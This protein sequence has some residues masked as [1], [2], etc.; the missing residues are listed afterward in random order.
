MAEWEI[1]KPLG[2]CSGTGR[3]IEVGE[4]YYAALIQTHEGLQRADFSKEYWQQNQPQVYCHWKSK[5]PNPEEKK[6]IFID[7]DM[8][9]TFFDRLQQESE[10]EKI[11]FRFVLA[12]VLMRKRR[13]KYQGTKNENGLEIWQLKVTGEDR[14][15]DV[16]NPQLDESQIEQLTGQIGQILQVDL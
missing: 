11:N 6:K 3:K 13:L 1:K 2:E 5:L 15:V 8:L 4:E 10:Q 7:D 14:V 9:L 12:L 16:A